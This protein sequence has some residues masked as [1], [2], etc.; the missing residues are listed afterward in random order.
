MS[1][2][3]NAVD[4]FKSFES[5][6]SSDP[7]LRRRPR[8]IPRVDL[9]EGSRA[10]VQVASGRRKLKPGSRLLRKGITLSGISRPSSAS[11]D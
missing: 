8:A 9:T 4:L 11:R 5:K 10:Q 2:E 7:T 1:K 3:A 6:A